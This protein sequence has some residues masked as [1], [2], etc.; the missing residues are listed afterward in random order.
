MAPIV[1]DNTFVVY[2]RPFKLN[3]EININI[4]ATRTV[5]VPVSKDDYVFEITIPAGL[6]IDI[7]A[8][9]QDVLLDAKAKWY[10]VASR[11]ND[12]NKKYVQIVYLGNN[13]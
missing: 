6:E 10:V 7:S 13:K 11:I 1:S 9:G 12:D 5:L 3:D 2:T 8:N 4:P